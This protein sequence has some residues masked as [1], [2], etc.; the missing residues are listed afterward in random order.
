LEGLGSLNS[1]RVK[2]KEKAKGHNGEQKG[3]RTRKRENVGL[4]KFA[5]IHI[6]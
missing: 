4:L 3:K 6:K 1:K 2:T 5:F